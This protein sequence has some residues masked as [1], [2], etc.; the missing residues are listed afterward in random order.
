MQ[1]EI[2]IVAKQKQT[3]DK[4]HKVLYNKAV[5]NLLDFKIKEVL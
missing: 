3:F 2:K 1:S 5:L 4:E